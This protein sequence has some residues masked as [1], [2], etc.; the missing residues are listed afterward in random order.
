MNKSFFDGGLFQ[1][2]AWRVLGL[3][4]TVCTFGLCYPW[5]ACMVYGWE[6]RHTVIDGHRLE[7]T[8]SAWGLFGLWIKWL[9]LCV[10]TLGIYS[11]W[12]CIS[13][14]KWK[15]AHTTFAN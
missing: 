10:L 9:I 6:T 13:I 5:A 2:I 12:V 3:I 14:R 15:A 7:F 11:F 1:L 8:G 4:V